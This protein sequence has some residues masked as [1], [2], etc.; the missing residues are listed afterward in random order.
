M[1][2]VTF[3]AIR[4]TY[5][6]CVS[7]ALGIQHATRMRHIELSTVARPPIQHISSLSYELHDFWGGGGGGN[8]EKKLLNI[9]CVEIFS[10]TFVRNVSHSYKNSARYN[11][12]CILM[13]NFLNGF[14]KNAQYRT[15]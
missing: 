6:E 13:L 1:Y 14:S 4:T 7:V 11:Q 9:K 2:D 12:K 15:S 10:T 3:R 8:M 5:S